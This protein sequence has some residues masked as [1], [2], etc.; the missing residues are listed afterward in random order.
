MSSAG[1]L[2][3]AM[4]NHQAGN[5]AAA[6]KEYRRILAK[7]PLDATAL[8]YLGIVLHQQA[9]AEEA[10]QI[11]TRAVAVA[12]KSAEAHFS[13]GLVVMDLGRHDEAEVALRT[14]VSLRSDMQRALTRLGEVLVLRKKD[15]E[16]VPFLNRAIELCPTDRK[17]WAALALALRHLNSIEQAIDANFRALALGEGEDDHAAMAD[18]IY[19]L[20][21]RDPESARQHANR[22]LSAYPNS[23]FAQHIAAG[24]LGLAAPARASDGYVKKLFDN[25]ADSFEEQLGSLGY[26]QPDIVED[27][28]GFKDAQGSLVVLDAGCGTGLA[29]PGLRRAASKLIGVDISPRMLEKAREKGLYDE[30]VEMELGEF[31]GSHEATFDLIV[32]ADVFIYFGDLASVMA[33]AARALRPGGSLVFTVEGSEK[34]EGFALGPHGRYG[35]TREYVLDVVK[36]AGLEPDEVQQKVLRQE[37]NKP[38]NGFVIQA[39]SGAPVP[40]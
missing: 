6:E 1:K 25:F 40:D 27:I 21:L 12:P 13:L 2:R 8:Y 30:L 38:V 39:R 7:Y 19:L 18:L 28:A 33:L 29:A 11:L 35:H 16:A 20:S 4:A 26:R 31:L 34:G 37:S 3:Q 5:L 9:K 32:A 36:R 10:R 23:A 17:A 14:A 15:Q 24:V 22:W